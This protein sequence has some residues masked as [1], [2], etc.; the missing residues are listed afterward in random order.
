MLAISQFVPGS[1]VD[2]ASAQQSAVT[3]GVYDPDR[4]FHAQSKITT[5]HY[6]LSWHALDRT[7]ARSLFRYAKLRNRQILATVEPFRRPGET[8]TPTTYLRQIAAGKYNA[9]IRNVCGVIGEQGVPVLVR[10]G[11]EMD[12]TS[13]RYP[14]AGGDPYAYITAYRYFRKI[15]LQSAPL[16]QFVWS[17]MASKDPSLYYPGNNFVHVI[18]LP[19]WGLQQVDMDYHRRGRSFAEILDEKYRYVAF[20]GKPVIV[21]EFGVSGDRAYREAV[22]SG[23]QAARKTHPLL[24]GVHYFN[25]KEP[26]PWWGNYGTPDWQVDPAWYLGLASASTAFTA[27][28]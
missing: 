2:S 17:P 14:W 25:M 1:L 28:R 8:G 12:D 22:F 11:H 7:W 27:S 21:A 10:W 20:R 13:G 19:I 9:E 24:R 3:L 16:A 15:C 5:E 23:I 26:F 18:G 4:S 6:F